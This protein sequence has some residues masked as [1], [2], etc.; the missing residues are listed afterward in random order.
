M[1]RRVVIT[2]MGTVNP[3][4]VNV[5]AY[6]EA[7]L[8]GRHG[9]GPITQFDHS[10]FKVHFAGEVPGYDAEKFLEAPLPRRLDRFA[11]FGLL[12]AR[13]AMK[14]SGLVMDREDPFR[15]GVAV[16]S[17][18]G[19]LNELENQR[20][21]FLRD[22]NPSRVSPF[23]IP[24]MIP[25]S[26]AG[27]ISMGYQLCGPNTVISTACASANQSIGEALRLIQYD[28]ADIMVAG[29][30]ESAI[31]TLG[32]GG[33]SQMKALSLRNDEPGR[34]SRPWDLD[35]DGFVLA[36]GAGVVVLEELEHARRRGATLYAELLGAAST[37]D[38]THITQPHKDGLGA[39]RAMEFALRNAAVKPEEIDYVNAHGTSTQLGDKAETLALKRVFGDHAYKLAVNSTKS[40][41]GHLLGASGAIE[42]I[43]VALTLQHGVIHPTINYE[44]PD[45]DCDLDYVPNTAREKRVRM[46]ISNSFG[47]GGH[48]CTLVVGAI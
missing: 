48:N 15:C 36:E 46:A 16:G 13:E 19:G 45:P 12:A 47:F 17:G 21:V 3:L 1:K 34:A 24:K 23:C 38:A 10:T 25:N 39:A 8:A 4:G 29:A 6:W 37:A 33:F 18:I 14:H 2:G 22:G 20:A 43:A 30:A 26:A 35:R 11:Q 42:L 40:M 27:Y 7:L 31:T 32:L 9:I 5:P 41:T 44:T 28:M